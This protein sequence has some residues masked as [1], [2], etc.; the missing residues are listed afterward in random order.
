MT[1][2]D[3]I[4]VFRW[5]MPPEYSQLFDYKAI[6]EH[7]EILQRRRGQPVNAELWRH[8]PRDLAVVCVSAADYPGLLSAVTTAFVLHRLSISTAQVYSYRDRS[9]EPQ[10]F[11][12]FWL[13]RR[14]GGRK[15]RRPPTVAQIESSIKTLTGFVRAR[16]IPPE[17]PMAKLPSTLQPPARAYFRTGEHGE[18]ELVIEA[19]DG[20][21]LMTHIARTLFELDMSIVSSDIRTEGGIATDRFVLAP[22]GRGQLDELG[23]ERISNELERSIDAWRRQHSLRVGA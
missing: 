8:Y 22:I 7:F 11:D 9:G 19:F 14:D 5:G 21:G 1:Q 2:P 17:V 12:L 10:A 20:P 18:H 6:G 15:D 23:R 4:T 16:A 3:E 13:R